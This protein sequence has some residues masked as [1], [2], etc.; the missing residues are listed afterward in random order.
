MPCSACLSNNGA[1]Y[2]GTVPNILASVLCF[3]SV[4]ICFCV[5]VCVPWGKEKDLSDSVSGLLLL[6]RGG[7]DCRVV[8]HNT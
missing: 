7:P 6:E 8:E 3:F 4:C 2:R 5:C 1:L